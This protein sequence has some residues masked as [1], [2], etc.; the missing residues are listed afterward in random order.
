[1]NLT[2][3]TVWTCMSALFTYEIVVFSYFRKEM[4]ITWLTLRDVVCQCILNLKLVHPAIIGYNAKLCCMALHHAQK[5]LFCLPSFKLQYF[6]TFTNVFYFDQTRF[7]FIERNF[8]LC[9]P[10]VWTL[11]CLLFYIFF[12]YLWIYLNFTMVYFYE[13]SAYL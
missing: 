13:Y 6:N 3:T 4:Y 10:I 2:C 11:S 1:M 7:L 12:I 5:M 9:L 8:F